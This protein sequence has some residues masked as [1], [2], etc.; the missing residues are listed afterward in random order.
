MGDSELADCGSDDEDLP[1]YRRGSPVV[2]S[3]RW[4]RSQGRR[5]RRERERREPVADFCQSCRSRSLRGERATITE[6]ERGKRVE[7]KV[8]E[9]R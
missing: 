6:T 9:E 3:R 4:P 2:W 7:R 1:R 5:Q 8:E